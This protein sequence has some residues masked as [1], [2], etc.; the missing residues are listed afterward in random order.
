MPVL[1]PL[2]C[3]HCS[4]PFQPSSHSSRNHQTPPLALARVW[5]LSHAQCVSADSA[6]P[7]SLS[8]V[9]PPLPELITTVSPSDPAS[10]EPPTA[11]EAVAASLASSCA[12]RLARP[13][14]ASFSS[15]AAGA[16]LTA[17]SPPG[18]FFIS[19]FAAAITRLS[20]AMP[21]PAVPLEQVSTCSGG[22]TSLS[23]TALASP[24]TSRPLL[25]AARMAVTP[26]RP[27]QR[28]S[29]CARTLLAALGPRRLRIKRRRVERSGGERPGVRC[30]SKMRPGSAAAAQKA[31]KAWHSSC[32]LSRHAV[33]E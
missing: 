10:S 18:C 2:V 24:A 1:L 28:T 29:M 31:S 26:P 27:R 8:H 9:A 33:S 11:I 6:R 25:S 20:R 22:A 19:A 23:S 32:S 15:M 13:L 7:P 30:S 21:A 5:P 17:S 4:I 3:A 16:S 14:S 12:R